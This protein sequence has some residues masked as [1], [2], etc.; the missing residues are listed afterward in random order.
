MEPEQAAAETLTENDDDDENDLLLYAH[1]T[2]QSQRFHFSTTNLC[3]K[4]Q[5]HRKVGEISIA[6][7]T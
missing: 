6:P 7:I 3:E 1:K 5:R 4:E 2:D